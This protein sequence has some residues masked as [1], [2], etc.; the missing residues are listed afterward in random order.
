LI[1]VIDQL[2]RLD[3]VSG[4]IT[5]NV[6]FDRES[7]DLI[8]G[9]I[10][11]GIRAREVIN[12]SAN[13][14]GNDAST[15][16]YTTIRIN[17]VDANDNSPKFAKTQFNVSIAEDIPN[18]SPLPGVILTVSDPDLADNAYFE[19]E[20]SNYNAE[21]EVSPSNGQGQTTASILIKD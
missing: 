13:I 21:F 11:L 1:S 6:T 19:F 5:T 18:Q 4:N 8:I 17:V 16:A 12:A 9:Y 15:T 10:D 3:P 2:V 14:L 7:Q 20:L